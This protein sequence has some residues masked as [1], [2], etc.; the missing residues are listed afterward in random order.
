LAKFGGSA[1][2]F[3]K[4]AQIFRKLPLAGKQSGWHT[5]SMIKRNAMSLFAALMV[6][7]AGISHATLTDFVDY[8]LGGY[9]SSWDTFSSG[10]YLKNFSYQTGTSGT[11]STSEAPM[12]LNATVPGWAAGGFSTWATGPLD[13]NGSTVGGNQDLFY[14]FFASSVLWNIGGTVNS[15][16]PLTEFVFQAKVASGSAGGLTN[17]LLNGV[18]ES[19]SDFDA[20]TNVYTWTWTDLNYSKGA[21]YNLTWDTDTQHSVIDSYQVQADAQAVP[22]PTTWALMALALGAVLWMK[23]GRVRAQA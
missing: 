7:G 23:R 1:A 14:T 17:V 9:T 11:P 18:S 8:D 2:G 15:D 10:N 19:S 20:A 4:E 12:T 5:A 3:R 22:E 13:S 6:A 21:F 16:E